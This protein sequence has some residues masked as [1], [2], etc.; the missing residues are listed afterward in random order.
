MELS[1]PPTQEDSHRS[2][3]VVSVIERDTV[4]TNPQQPYRDHAPV[5]PYGPPAPQVYVR[6]QPAPPRGL[7]IASM[8]LGIASIFF[9]FTFIVPITGLILGFVGFRKEPAGHGMAIA[10]II[11]NGLVLVGAIAIGLFLLLSF[12]GVLGTGLLYSGR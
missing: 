11:L 1:Q 2:G 12:A 4:M 10:G 6:Y 3:I 7:S 9:G 5:Q 8:V